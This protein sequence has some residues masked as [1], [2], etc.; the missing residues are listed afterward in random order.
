MDFYFAQFW[1]DCRFKVHKTREEALINLVGKNVE[2]LWL[3][4]TVFINSKE[5]KYHDVTV[6]N[7]FLSVNLSN[8]N[9]V[10]HAR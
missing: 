3:P 10:Y 6:N 4:D 5:S 9:V 7:R 8:G 2:D 1:D